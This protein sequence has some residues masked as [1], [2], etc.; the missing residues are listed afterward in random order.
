MTVDRGTLPVADVTTGLTSIIV[1]SRNQRHLLATLVDSLLRSLDGHRVELIIVDNGSDDEETPRW[2]AELPSRLADSVFERIRV[3]VDPSP[4]N[5]SALNNLA[6]SFARGDVLCLLND[7]IEALA[8][9]DWLGAMLALARLPDV[10]CVGAKLIFPDDTIQH[11]GIMLGLDCV[12]GH[13]YRGAPHDAAG[14]A[15]YLRKVQQVSAVTG[16]CLVLERAIYEQVG[17][18][19]ERLPIAWNDVDLCL[20]VASAGYRNLWTP[21]AVLRH[22]ESASRRRSAR[23]RGAR[24]RHRESIAFMRSRWGDALAHDPHLSNPARTGGATLTD[25]ARREPARP[26]WWQRSIHRLRRRRLPPG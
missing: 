20:R 1:P 21:E 18:L 4:F 11:A 10:G 3:V 16:A 2:L 17:G 9:H 7:D 8:D 5:Y 14:H 15:D 22:H 26:R 25:S 13:P 19:D 12:A 23:S 6:A 24:R